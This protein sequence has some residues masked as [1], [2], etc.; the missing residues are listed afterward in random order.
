MI[1]EVFHNDILLAIIIRNH[2]YKSG[3]NFHTDSK[4]EFQIATMSHKSGYAITPHLHNVQTRIINT[5]SEVIYIK[6]G[7][8]EVNF[9]DHNHYM[10]NNVHL[11]AGDFIY[12]IAM[13]HGFNIIDDVE[14]LE[15][16]QGP[17]YK[18]LDKVRFNG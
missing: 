6:K 7:I 17:F 12:L 16:K 18:N 3:I 14:L 8:L 4:S 9:Y 13:A 10:I 5:T 15:I 11:R 1:E 2:S